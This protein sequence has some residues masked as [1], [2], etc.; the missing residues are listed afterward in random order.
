MASLFLKRS[1]KRPAGAALVI[2]IFFVGI[3]TVLVVAFL[4][5]M[6]TERRAAQAYHETARA[7]LI[8]QGA[9]SHAI[10]LLR[11]NIPEPARLAEGPA[12][13]AAV[14]WIINPGQLTIVG[15]GGTKQVPLHSGAVASP[16]PTRPLDYDS[17]DLNQPLPGR[18]TPAITGT[19]ATGVSAPP[20]RVQWVNVLR[21]PAQAA[22]ANNPL[23]GRYAFW[24][25]D[26]CA[27][28]NFNVAVGKPVP[29]TGNMFG[30]Q[31]A[32]GFTTPL[33]SRGDGSISV[34]GSK[35]QWALGR[36]QSV[37]LDVLFD[38]PAQL[39]SNGLL[40]QVFLHGFNKYPE[41]IMDYADVPSPR[42][43]FDQRKFSL[44][45]YS[46]SPE[47][48]AFGQS[49]IFTTFVPLSLEAGPSYQHPFIYDSSG[50]FDGNSQEVLHLN[51]LLGTFGF[52]SS[53]ASDDGGTVNGGN[54]VNRAQLNLLLSYM[55]RR[56]P[57]YNR[58]FYDKYGPTECAQ[59]A[60]NILLMARMSTSQ[61]SSDLTNFSSDWGL[62]TTSVNYS[63]SSNEMP[64]CTPERFYWNIQNNG[65]ST[66]MLPQTPGPH[67][68]EV[69]LFVKPVPA[70]PPPK[71]SAALL[72]GYQSPCYIQYYYEVEYYMHPFGPV[73]DLSQFPTR[74]DYL[75]VTASGGGQSQRQ[76]F[77]PSDPSDTRPARNWNT[78]G[79]LALLQA[80]P[81]A[82][83]TLGPAGARFQGQAVP[84]RR[85]VRSAIAVIGQN[86]TSVPA[87]NGNDYSNWSPLV[88]DP[89]KGN[90]VSVKIH[91]RPGMGIAAAPARP[92][93]MIPLGTTL[94]DTLKADNFIVDLTQLNKEQVV[95]W[96]ISD[97]RLSW[98]L[99]Q[100]ESNKT[101]PGDPTSI[102]TPG[103]QNVNEPTE[104]ATEKSKFRY[105]ERGPTG[106]TIAGY[107]VDRPDEY[108]PASRVS[109]PGYWSLIHTGMQS[110]KP[111][112]TLNFGPDS[113][114]DSP[115]DW[116]LLDLFGA[117]Y[118]M[119][120]AQWQI[121]NTLP[122]QFSTVSFMNSTAG[123]VNLNSRIYPRTQYFNVPDRRLPLKAVFQNLPQVS[124]SLV[125]E[126]V[127]YQSD[128][129]GFN[130]VGELANLPSVSGGG[131]TQWDREFL[132]RNLA[133]CLTTK[134]NTFG[135]W[136]V[137]QVVTKN[138][139]NTGFDRFERGDQV[140]AEKRFFALV[141]RYVWPGRDG[142]PGNGHAD[143][144][145]RWDR[146]A[147]Q[148]SQIS[149][150][151][152][153]TDTLFQ[154]PGSPPLTR[155]AGQT[156]LN[157]DTSGSYPVFDGP[158]AVGTDPYTQAALGGVSYKKSSL[159][160]ADNPPQAVIKYRV[161]YFK[162]LDQ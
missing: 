3:A 111:W 129:K 146:L 22:G 101:G 54:V 78:A 139:A 30:D 66:L 98:D 84:N 39:N 104:S 153:A 86:V 27:R 135:V 91:F 145:G 33:F 140:V 147:R 136:G 121:D 144:S 80:Q 12:T 71:N 113:G 154:L 49:R 150:S 32:S 42:A 82:G 72:K 77:G 92:R 102:G 124:A 55:Q 161:V 51:S 20:M 68:M 128:Q 110:K 81:A 15:T 29:A 112:R 38:N 35:P 122:D 157:L 5:T 131:S 132:L 43:W 10:D 25:D 74:M 24:I 19:P 75:E 90:S 94:N 134:S 156:R 159:E 1:P 107:A 37:N 116:L 87:I 65:Q 73:V 59:I 126:I 36:P 88:F 56:W 60:L 100:W 93:Q 46:R 8:A 148:A 52:T 103:Q 109:S 13:S 108:E 142:V 76:Q 151:G 95:S 7:K 120:H 23:A 130:Y 152:G 45:F 162:Y 18:T 143:S 69:R 16:D 61:I 62:R 21:D 85:V 11:T 96:Q 119:A 53:V 48:N 141:E 41:A 50:A 28:L 14:N 118:P 63:P 26:E 64:G 123:Q 70:D 44:T 4:S 34:S 57:G 155:T 31:L 83:L 17:V 160:E 2:T 40:D 137:S 149:I 105:I 127:D 97:P 6:R 125:D 99:N 89:A 114:Q 47:F 79:N 158:E 117:T 9:V 58:S 133:G 106:E 138:R 115:P 67:I